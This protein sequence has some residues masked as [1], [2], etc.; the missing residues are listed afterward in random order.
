[1]FMKDLPLRQQNS[2]VLM[3]EY[4]YI[5]KWFDVYYLLYISYTIIVHKRWS[6]NSA[7]HPFGI[8]HLKTWSIC[9]QIG[10]EQVLKLNKIK[11]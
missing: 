5:P 1:M 8:Y 10:S 9:D 4:F 7:S 2:N 11:G 3:Y 6:L